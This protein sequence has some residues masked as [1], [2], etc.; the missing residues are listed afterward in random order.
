MLTYFIKGTPIP[1]PIILFYVYKYLHMYPLRCQTL[2]VLGCT[3]YYLHYVILPALHYLRLVMDEIHWE[4][5]LDPGNHTP[6][7]P[8]LFTGMVD[9]FPMR[10]QQPAESEI[11]RRLYN[12]KYKFCIFKGQLGIDFLGM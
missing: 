9:T 8:F 1:H 5:R 7:F 4:D 12:P 3:R 6:H 10:V 2:T 11:R